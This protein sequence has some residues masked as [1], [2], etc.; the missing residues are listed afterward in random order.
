MSPRTRDAE[1][2]GGCDGTPLV[3]GDGSRTLWSE[4]YGESYHSRFGAR[5]EARHV[6][7][8]G[9]GVADRLA[10]GRPAAV[11]EVGF[12]AGLNA[13]LTI[14]AAAAAGARLRYVALERAL[15]PAATLEALG[16]RELLRDPGLADALVAWRATFPAAPVGPARLMLGSTRLDLLL[17]DAREAALPSGMDAVYHDAFSPGANPE[18]WEP[19]FL[20]R[21]LGALQPGG[22]LVSYTVQGALRRRLAATGF[23]VARVPGPPG[24]KRQV[25]VATKPGLAAA[26]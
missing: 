20:A 14:D 2:T 19:G 15:L 13:L 8:E 24:G 11:L 17:G 23:R 22:R 16:Y 1:P 12:G 5:A 21:L 18:L 3:T 7:L 25:L 4:R 10:G 6:F 26:P 9:S